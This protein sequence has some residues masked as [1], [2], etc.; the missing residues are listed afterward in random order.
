MGG[1]SS[2]SSVQQT[3]EFF[4]QSTKSF[5]SSLTQ[6]VAATGTVKQ[7]V[8]FSDAVFTGCHVR[9]TQTVIQTINAQGQ[10]KAENSADL[11]S[12]L[13]N[14]ANTAIDNSASQHNGFL[15]P[16]VGNSAQ[17]TTD[18]KTK[19]TNIISTT[20]SS[21][22]VQDIIAA[23]LSNQSIDAHGM[24]GTCDPKYHI[25]GE[26]DFDFDQNIT[27]SITAK[28]IADAITNALVADSSVTSA[29]T[30]VKQSATQ[31]NAGVDDLVK[32]FTGIYGIICGV[33]CCIIIVIGVVMMS[34]GKGGGGG[35]GGGGGFNMA[36]LA[37][38]AKK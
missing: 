24:V 29:V 3:N 32:A 26:Y 22:T 9:V 12:S 37:A 34:M 28:G 30:S 4:N 18:L 1:N 36:S 33:I 27:Q 23:G 6:N 17:A 38:M 15:A 21:K 13:A 19:V 11:T 8:N 25:A 5:M 10:L 14:S 7:N 31:S 16:A 35:G 2:K 20:V